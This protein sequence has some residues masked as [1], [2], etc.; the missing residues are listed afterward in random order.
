MLDKRKE[1]MKFLNELKGLGL[2]I[3]TEGTVINPI[4]LSF[5]TLYERILWLINKSPNYLTINA[6][7]SYLGEKNKS[8]SKAMTKLWRDDKNKTDYIRRIGID[9]KRGYKANIPKNLDIPS[10]Y[11]VM[12][13][14][15]VRK[16]NGYIS[17]ED[18]SKIK[19]FD[20][21]S[22]IRELLSSGEFELVIRRINI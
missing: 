18:Q 6:I 19:T 4:K 3:T 16:Q 15:G 2:Q 5:N 22:T 12:K 17:P 11:K 8:V 10:A 9:R 20:E 13:D 14:L 7:A 1:R 21:L